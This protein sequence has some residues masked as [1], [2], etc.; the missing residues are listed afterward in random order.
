M[1]CGKP[2]LIFLG[3]QDLLQ[4]INFT[5]FF[6]LSHLLNYKGSLPHCI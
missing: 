6:G 1:F 3:E 5:L 4:I 2:L